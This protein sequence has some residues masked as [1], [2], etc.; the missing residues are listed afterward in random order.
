M[1][2]PSYYN[3][4][5]A[6]RNAPASAADAS[7]FEETAHPR[8][9][10]GGKGGG[11]FTKKPETLAKEDERD[12][13]SPTEGQA[14][15]SDDDWDAVSDAVAGATRASSYAP[16][17]HGGAE[18]VDASEDGDCEIEFPYENADW[19]RQEFPSNDSPGAPAGYEGLDDEVESDFKAMQKSLAEKGYNLEKDDD[20]VSSAVGDAV[21]GMLNGLKMADK[22]PDAPYINPRSPTVTLKC[23]VRKAA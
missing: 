9:A 17:K 23:R 13:L 7:P 22:D 2:V 19:R 1:S 10:K 6:K 12:M 4:L 18:L 11:Q 15:M 20:A 3:W 5:H 14:A 21:S 8:T 16:E